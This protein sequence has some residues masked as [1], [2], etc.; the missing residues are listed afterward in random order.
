MLVRGWAKTEQATALTHA[1]LAHAAVAVGHGH[2]GV[3]HGAGLGQRADLAEYLERG[4][5][6]DLRC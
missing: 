2:F 3:N 6:I 1:P 4:P 5:N